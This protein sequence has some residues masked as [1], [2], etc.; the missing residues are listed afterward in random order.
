ME[1][2]YMYLVVHGHLGVEMQESVEEY[3][4]NKVTVT[5]SLEN[6]RVASTVR[7]VG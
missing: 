5:Q 6:Q 3:T 7:F 2:E 4:L 1:R